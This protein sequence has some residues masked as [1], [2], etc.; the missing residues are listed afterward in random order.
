M[1]FLEAPPVAGASAAAGTHANAETID[2]AANS[3]MNWERMTE[4]RTDEKTG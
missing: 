3:G 2:T 4:T 1:A